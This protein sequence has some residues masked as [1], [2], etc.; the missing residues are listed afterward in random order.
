MQ[1]SRVAAPVYIP[2]NS[3]RG[4]PFPTLILVFL[5]I[6][7]QTV[8]RWYLIVVLVCTSLMIMM[9]NIFLCTCLSSVC[10]LW[11][12]V[13]SDPL[14][15]FNRIVWVFCYCFYWVAWVLYIFCTLTPLHIYDLH[16]FSPIHLVSFSFCWWIPLLC[17]SFLVWYS[18]T[19]KF[20][21]LVWDLKIINKTDVKERTAYVFL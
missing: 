16:I 14:P 21:L 8:M 6:A 17:R 19:C 2:T 4:F 1:F 12:N 10:L 7:I 20:L 11:K 18:P 9:L 3:A 5:I 13:C 15:F